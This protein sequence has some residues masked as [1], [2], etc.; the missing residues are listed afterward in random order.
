MTSMSLQTNSSQQKM[1]NFD[2]PKPKITLIIKQ[3][4]QFKTIS[5]RS[6]ARLAHFGHVTEVVGKHLATKHVAFGHY[7]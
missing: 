3:L 7:F 1:N 2:S 6:S 4:S 5:P